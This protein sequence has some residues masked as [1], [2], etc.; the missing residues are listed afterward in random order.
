MLLHMQHHQDGFTL[1]E[2]LIAMAMTGIILAALFTFAIAQGQY[3]STREQVTQMT[4]GARAAMDMLTHEI[5]I[6]GYNPRRAAF[7]G[8][9]YNALQLQL[10]A[11]L[12]GD[13]GTGALDENIIYTYDTSTR[14]ILRNTGDG[15]EPLADHIEAFTVGYLDANGNPTTVSAN[16]RQ[17]RISITARTA[18]PDP[19]YSTNGG[20]RSYLLTS[21]ITPRN[22]AYP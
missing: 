2:L 21:L 6:A 5:E 19:H 8:V 17:L 12:D 22:L 1:I 11:D 10:Q 15:N 3:L 16:I 9:T 20:Y 18:K 14:Q 4:Q 7:F 13:G